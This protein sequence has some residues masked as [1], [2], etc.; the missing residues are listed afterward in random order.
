M[1]LDTDG[2]LF[3]ELE[4]GLKLY[5]LCL[6]TSLP[7]AV[8]VRVE[9][10]MKAENRALYYRFLSTLNEISELVYNGIYDRGRAF[11]KGEVVVD[12][13]ARIGTFAAKI[14]S[15]VGDDGKIVAIEPEPNNY[16]CL[17]KN[18]EVNRLHNVIPVRKMLWSGKQDMRLFLSKYAAA[19]SAYC[20]AFFASTGESIPVEAD[21]LDN[22]L[23]G[24]GLGPVGFIKM[25]IEG[26]ETEALKGM[27]RTLESDLQMAIAAYHPIDGQ[28][29]HTISIAQ[30]ET[31][32]FHT[33]FADG[34]VRAS[35]YPESY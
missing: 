21:S 15:A 8:S 14:S 13:G 16:R 9:D 27:E 23:K 35:R 32:G 5:D 33:S 18:I 2:M 1:G 22:V 31:L 24:L 25:D 29:A 17:L 12:A 6:N 10:L 28:S 19:H 34:I 20:D 11:R 4:N 3:V 26:S 30:L 7:E